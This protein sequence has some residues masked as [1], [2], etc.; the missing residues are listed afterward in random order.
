MTIGSPLAP[1]RCQGGPARYS[2][3]IRVR[4]HYGTYNDRGIAYY[5]LGDYERA[6]EDYRRVLDLNPELAAAY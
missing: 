5:D 2:A 3:G 1:S 4:P 6:I